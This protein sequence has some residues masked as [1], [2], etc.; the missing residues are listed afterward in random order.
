MLSIK[1]A[2]TKGCLGVTSFTLRIGVVNQMCIDTVLPRGDFI[3]Y[4]HGC[5]QSNFALTKGC[6]GVT[7]FV[8]PM[9]V[10]NQMCI[11]KGLAR[12]DIIHYACGCCQS[13]VH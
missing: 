11:D 5:C 1:H 2:L 7:S 4:A 8:M 3:C 12:G 10:V 6:L 13:N 9:A